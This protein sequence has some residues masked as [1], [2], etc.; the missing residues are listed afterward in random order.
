MACRQQIVYPED[1]PKAAMNAAL[2]ALQA[3]DFDTYMT[4]VDYGA[5]LDS[6]ELQNMKD[7]L[8]RH[9]EW[10]QAE[11]EHVVSTRVVDVKMQGDTVCTAYYQYVF[12]DS[13]RETV[14][15]KMVYRDGR[16]KIRIRN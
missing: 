14:S 3:G 1:A 5:D 11:R 16:W 6:A 7:V 12:A 8:R 15:Q 10:K 9:E 13:C 2:E 4:Y